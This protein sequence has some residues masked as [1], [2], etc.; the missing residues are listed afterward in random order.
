MR[1]RIIYYFICIIFGISSTANAQRLKEL[2]PSFYQ[3]KES[4]RDLS[5]YDSKDNSEYISKHRYSFYTKPYSFKKKK[6]VQW[7][8]APKLPIIPK[9]IQIRCSNY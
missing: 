6:P 4:K 7:S 5:I 1:K 8:N 3:K 9:K 2:T